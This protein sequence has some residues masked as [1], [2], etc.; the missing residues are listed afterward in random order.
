MSR[1]L[2]VIDGHPDRDHRHFVHA[3]ADSYVQGAEG[4][5]EVRRLTVAEL[6]FPVL[7]SQHDWAEGQIPEAIADAQEALRWAE[8]IVLFYPMWL[9]DVPALLKAFLEQVM[10]PGFAFAYRD[11]GLP[12]KRLKGRSAR[13]VVTMGMPAFF[14]R[15]VYRAHSLKSLERNILNFVG[16]KPVEKSVIGGVEADADERQRWLDEMRNLGRQGA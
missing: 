6:D 13:V 10:R 3:L 8:H 1:R 11:K 12:E 4:V 9:G 7:R 5:H 2:L 15:L 16:I 14:Y